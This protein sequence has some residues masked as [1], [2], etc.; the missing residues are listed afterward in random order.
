M[1][2]G[3][4]CL[5]NHSNLLLLARSSRLPT[6]STRLSIPSARLFTRCSQPSIC[7]STRSTRLSTRSVCLFSRNNRLFIRF[8]THN[9]CSTICPS[10]YN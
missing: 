3:T 4:T 7:P 1:H 10:F 5:I 8:S 6:R 9:T 2:Y